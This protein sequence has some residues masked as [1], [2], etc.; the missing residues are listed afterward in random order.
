MKKKKKWE[1]LIKRDGEGGSGPIFAWQLNEC[2]AEGW[3]LIHISE[4][5]SGMKT[6]TFKR[7]ADS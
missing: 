3:E 4:N 2:G 6:Y 7:K 1:Y 5:S